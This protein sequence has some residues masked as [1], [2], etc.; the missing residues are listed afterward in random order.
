[1]NIYANCSPLTNRICKWF[2][3][4]TFQPYRQIRASIL[5]DSA[6]PQIM[7]HANFFSFFIFTANIFKDF[8]F[9]SIYAGQPLSVK[10][11]EGLHLG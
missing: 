3:D 9:H 8:T 11:K 7:I 2:S 5:D 4:T 10:V 1:M 6:K